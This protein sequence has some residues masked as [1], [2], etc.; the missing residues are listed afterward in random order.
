MLNKISFDF[1]FSAPPLVDTMAVPVSGI[2]TVAGVLPSQ[3]SAVGQTIGVTV[4]AAVP[5]A[6]TVV[7][8][9]LTIP[10]TG[11]AIVSTRGGALKLKSK[12]ILLSTSVRILERPLTRRMSQTCP[13]VWG[14]GGALVNLCRWFECV[15]C[16]SR[17]SSARGSAF[18]L[19]VIVT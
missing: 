13:A 12:L 16:W 4:S 5:V 1:N 6:P 8:K 9:Q 7:V 10:L 15:Q 2:V 19:H 11:T 14:A 3:G 18:R 17:D